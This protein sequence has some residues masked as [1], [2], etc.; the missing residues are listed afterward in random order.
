[1]RKPGIRRIHRHDLAEIAARLLRVQIDNRP[2][3]EVIAAYDT[4][5]TLFYCDPP[6]PH[7]SRG[8][9]KAY[10]FEMSNA[11]HEKLAETLHKVRGKV[12]IS[13]YM[14]LLMEK[15]YGNWRRID[16]PEKYCHSVKELR[17]EALWIN[18]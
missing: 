3:H 16:A 8:D 15:L 17:Q 12:A 6:Y 13:G 14:C 11:E 10:G 2:A 18:Y 5:D 7:E 4:P 1:M 9:S